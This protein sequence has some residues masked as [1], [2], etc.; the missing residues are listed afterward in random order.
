MTSMTTT[1]IDWPKD[2]RP[3]EKLLAH[4]ANALSDAEL[5]AI[6]IR[7]GVKGKTAVDIARALLQKFG[8]VKKLLDA[9]QKD[10]CDSLGLGIAKYAQLQAVLELSRRYLSKHVNDNDNITS[11]A[12]AKLFCAMCLSKHQQEVFSAV[13]LDNNNH[14]VHYAELFYGTINRATI[15]PREVIKRALQYNAAA[16][17]VAH[18]HISGSIEPSDDDHVVTRRLKEAVALMDMKLLDHIIVG[19]GECFSF[20]EAKLL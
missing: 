18:N 1:I 8:N 7:C 14:V 3:R 17:I 13:F 12:T 15:Y 19:N 4:G 20:A 5:L 11:V 16:L 10:F 6:F 2:E 9:N